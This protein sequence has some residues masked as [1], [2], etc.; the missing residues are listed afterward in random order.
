MGKAR[1]YNPTVAVDLLLDQSRRLE[2]DIIEMKSDI[3]EA[4]GRK[5]AE[6]RVKLAE[7][8]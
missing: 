8:R 4:A 5:D 2:P 7:P 6:F 1:T 3:A